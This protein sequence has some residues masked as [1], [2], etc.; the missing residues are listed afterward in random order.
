MA[1][2]YLLEF[3]GSAYL[4]RQLVE[5]QDTKRRLFIMEQAP[6]YQLQ[7]H[8]LLKTDDSDDLAWLFA[9]LRSSGLLSS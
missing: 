8:L 4:P 2:A 6:I 1:L 7:K 9:L 5:V 3:G